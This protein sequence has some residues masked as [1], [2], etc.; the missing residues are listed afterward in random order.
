[1]EWGYGMGAKEEQGQNDPLFPYSYGQF[2]GFE[3]EIL[4]F[5]HIYPWRFGKCLEN[6]LLESLV[7][8]RS[9]SGDPGQGGLCQYCPIP[10]LYLGQKAPLWDCVKLELE[11]FSVIKS[12]LGAEVL[13][14]GDSF[15]HY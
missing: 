8:L 7:P 2:L 1:M 13:P 15:G 3:A 10:D 5:L 14:W 4:F 12:R 9:L 6:K 11:M